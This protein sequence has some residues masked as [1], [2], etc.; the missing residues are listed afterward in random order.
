M[1]HRLTLLF[2]L[3]LF[4]TLAGCGGRQADA[5]QNA[6]TAPGE[7]AAE[8]AETADAAPEQEES[9]F[10]YL[11]ETTQPPQDE[12]E[13]PQELSDEEKTAARDEGLRQKIA[14]M[15]VE[16]KVGQLFFVRCPARDAAEL[17]A[18]WHLGGVLLFTRDYQDESGAWLGREAF[19]AKLDG[20]QDAARGDL[21]I[22][23]FIGTDEEG[24]TVARASRNPN[25]FPQ[26]CASPQ[27]LYAAGGLG[28]IV[29]DTMEKS[30]LLRA[31]GINVNF[32]PVCD[33]TADSTAFIY[34]RTLGQDAETTS[35]YVAKVVGVM[36]SAGIGSV[37]KHFPGYGGNA[38]THTG[39]AL[40]ERSFDHFDTVDFLPFEAGIDAGAP[41]VLV[42]HNIVTCMDANLPA[43]LSPTV[44]RILRG[45]LHFDGVIL[46]DDL[47]MAGAAVPEGGSSV[48][49]LA[50]KA[51][52]D[53]LVTG[54][55]ETQIAEVLDAVEYGSITEK[56][57][58]DA[59]FR[60]L[61]AKC[62]LGLLTLE[63]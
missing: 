59:C 8:P 4:L 13:A 20:L 45:G 37:L 10:E 31:L 15:S 29:N 6:E 34:P 61:R 26:K 1:K 27:E 17:V 11:P 62:E 12:A 5:P 19:T 51:G 54:D 56:M 58:D 53:M 33:M 44:H 32:A 47:D 30:Y 52:N 42:S 63:D 43:S 2:I 38:D 7:A 25:L 9:D 35:A 60:I 39:V 14:G 22:P 48:A 18:R 41:F 36:R 46:T 21:G 40:D 3:C 57:L 24:G 49:V 16:E 23:L 28:A 55:F 50:V